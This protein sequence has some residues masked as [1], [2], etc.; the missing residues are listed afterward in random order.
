MR[1]EK[2]KEAKQ[3]H[4]ISYFFCA[5]LSHFC[6]VFGCFPLRG[7]AS[8]CL[9]LLTRGGV[10]A[11]RWEYVRHTHMHALASR[12]ALFLFPARPVLFT[13]MIHIVIILALEGENSL[14]WP[15][16]LFSWQRR[17]PVAR[18][19][20][21]LW[22]SR[23]IIAQC[24]ATQLLIGMTNRSSSLQKEIWRSNM[25]NYP[26]C[27]AGKEEE[28]KSGHDTQWTQTM[29]S[30]LDLTLLRFVNR[31]LRNRGL[32]VGLFLFQCKGGPRC[33]ISSQGE[34]QKM[35]DSATPHQQLPP[36]TRFECCLS[37][38]SCSFEV[39]TID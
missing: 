10:T 23:S 32:L 1:E 29:M 4:H 24:T 25:I 11:E 2:R 18:Q 37:S 39:P 9:T 36:R 35:C 26:K 5:F 6:F 28:K 31:Q 34:P 21:W 17:A 20:Q 33:Q 22:R 30:R 14:A 7:K 3:L 38:I 8:P 13:C 27:H 16:V 15:L 19:Y 12:Q